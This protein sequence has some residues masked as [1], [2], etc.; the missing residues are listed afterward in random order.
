[1][2]CDDRGYGELGRQEKD[3][4]ETQGTQRFAEMLG[5]RGKAGQPLN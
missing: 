3:S 4:A 2:T 1:M 5:S